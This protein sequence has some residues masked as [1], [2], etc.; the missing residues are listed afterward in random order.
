MMGIALVGTDTA[1]S[2][3]TVAHASRPA[4]LAGIPLTNR[5]L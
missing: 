3:Q 4:T 1:K 2:G 5:S